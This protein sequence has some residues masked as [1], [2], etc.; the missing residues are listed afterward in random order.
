MTKLM[1]RR[2]ALMAAQGGGG[3]PSIYRQVEWIGCSTVGPFIRTNV[4]LPNDVEVR[5][6]VMTGTTGWTN[7]Y[8]TTNAEFILQPGRSGVTLWGCYG[9][10][11]GSSSTANI[12]NSIHD[13]V[14][15]SAGV[16]VDGEKAFS[17]ENATIS[18]SG[19]N[20]IVFGGYTLSA[21]NGAGAIVGRFSYFRILSSGVI[22]C[23]LVPCYR[24][25]DGEIGMFDLVS[26]TF[27][28]NAGT[29]TFT[30]GAD[31]N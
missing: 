12:K 18:S 8:G 31:V 11:G 5:C 24:K 1:Q 22:R 17:F 29:G 7:V 10:K 19:K 16:W 6:G 3:L 4:V 14:H 25:A 15:N 13:V 26:K 2:R 21:P 27:L 23:D 28:T 9:N 30:K 20:V